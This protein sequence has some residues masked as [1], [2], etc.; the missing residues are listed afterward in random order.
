MIQ[1]LRKAAYKHGYLVITAAWLYTIS[2]IFIN[3]WNY[4]ASPQKVR[5]RLEQRLNNQEHKIRDILTDTAVLTSLTDSSANAEK[6]EM[7]KEPFG[8][9]IYQL[10]EDGTPVQIY[11]NTNRI[12]ITDDDLYRDDSSYFSEKRNGQFEVIRTPVKLRGKELLVMAAIPIRWAYFIEN[13]YLHSDFAGYQGLDQQYAISMEDDALPVHSSNG[14]VLFSIQQ[15]PGKSFIS[16][17]SVTVLFRVLAVIFLLVF[18]NAIGQELSAKYGFRRGFI[19]LLS[20]VLLLRLIAYRFSF[21]F[22]YSKLPLY[23]PAI[24]GSNFLHPSLGDLLVNSILLFWLVNF[25]RTH[26]DGRTWLPRPFPRHIRSYGSIMLLTVICF[27]LTGVVRSLVRDS[28]VSLDVTNLFSLSIYSFVCFLILCF[29]VLTFFHFSQILISPLKEPLL[30]QLAAAAITGFLYQVLFVKAPSIPMHMA[31]LAWLL[32]YLVLLYYRRKDMAAPLI[33]SGFF[34]FWVM[35]FALSISA[36]VMYQNRLVELGQRKKIAEKLAQQTDPSGENLLNIAATNF[37]D[38][39]LPDNFH[40]LE[41]EYSNKFIKDSLINQNFSGYLNKYDTRIYTFDSLYHPLYN[42]DSTGYA[43]IKTIILNQADPTGIQG[44]YS[45]DD[46]AIDGFSYL[47]EREISNGDRT[48]GYLYVIMK[49]K[50]YKSEALYPELFNQAQDVSA[51]LNI[52]YAYAVYNKGRLINHFNNYS[53]PAQL[54]SKQIPGFEFT[55]VKGNQYNELWYN[56]GGNKQVVIVKRNT[57]MMEFITLF[58][59]LFCSFLVIIFLFH[60]SSYFL[61]ARF[62]W[63]G[64]KKIFLLT[65]R[66][67]IQA[68]IIFLSVFSFLVI[69]VATISFFI[70]R[71]NR[72]NEERLSKSIQVMAN[73]INN[74]VNAQISFDDMFTAH[75][76]GVTSEMERTMSDISDLHNVDINFYDVSGNLKLS[77]QP[78]IYNKFL[79][80]GKMEPRAYQQMHFDRNIRYVQ[81]EK[82]GAFSYLSIYVPLTDDAG[83]NYAYLN[84]PYLNS[85]SEL[86]QEISGFLATLINLNAFIFLVAG[87]IAFFLTNRITASFS[88]IGDK[89]RKMNLG[90]INEEIQWNRNDEI[91]MLVTEYNKM[92]KKL[93]ASARALAQ[94]E[95]EGAWREMARQVAH[96]IKN[97]LTPMKLSIQYLQKAIRSGAPNVQELSENMAETLIEQIDQLSKIAGDFSQFAN[98]GNARMETFDLMEVV[99]SVLRLYQS[100]PRVEISW[101]KPEETYMVFSDRVQMNRLFTNLLQNAVEA[102]EDTESK[103]HVAIEQQ[104]AGGKILIAVKDSSGGIPAAMRKNIFTPNFTTKSSGTGLGLAICKGIVENANGRIWFESEEGAGTTFFIELPLA[105]RHQR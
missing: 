63:S 45:Y 47:Y 105:D 103:V 69:G 87:A 64:M 26:T 40:R 94:N 95:R 86:N 79:L 60:I 35:L 101:Q 72:N 93:E 99:T 20:V 9:F 53:F 90:T 8:L 28:K 82:V 58:A 30:N 67:Q 5:S 73:E 75:N 61:K 81:S 36:M 96:E 10:T 41:S 71:F 104:A 2:F 14:K 29:L 62:K 84:I 4:N 27:L 59:Y 88:L 52:N 32:L 54:T 76:I 25:Y 22:D 3:Y 56:S 18:C 66:S 46:N 31:V 21:P 51:D 48:L 44:L 57:W 1:T 7:V 85:Q 16:Y 68:T 50:R 34:I 43:A 17:D 77:T 100:N 38:H 83:N 12:Y 91:G 97:P 37:N 74:K 6:D 24:Y 13:K 15:K 89:M 78:Y 65:I 11:W 19:F 42:E 98:I 80:S 33:Q 102:C 39:F 23:D 49:S 92:V 70:L 55:Y